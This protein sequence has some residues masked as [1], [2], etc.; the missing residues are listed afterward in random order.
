MKA[1][2]S[3]PG[4]V[5]L[6]GEHFV[7][8]GE[9]ALVMAINRYVEVDVEERTDNA[10]YVSTNLGPSGFFKGDKFR[11]ERGGGEARRMLEPIKISAEETLKSQGER[12]GLSI[13]VASTLPVA[14]GLGSSGASAVATVAAVGRLLGADLARESIIS[15][16]TEAERYVHVNPSGIDQSIS[17]YGGVLSYRKSEGILRLRIESAVPVV[18]GNTGVSRNTG[19]LVDNVWVRVEQV[20]SVMKPLIEAAGKLT[21]QA[22]D[23]LKRGDLEEMGLLMN[24]NH[25]LLTA[26]GVS[27]EELD[28]LIY[29]ARRGGALGAKLTGAG[30]GG[31]MVALTRVERKEAVARSISDAGGA[32]MIVEKEDQGVRSWIVK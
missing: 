31:C 25:G 12:H 26:L 10:I 23:A 7:V 5:I 15:L 19:K 17:A 29:A 2:A 27:S 22:I 13:E 21:N 6:I 9:P 32:P 3:A 14:V 8:Y 24:V 18:I 4:K 16:A 1:A 28:R 11:P 30:G 20:P